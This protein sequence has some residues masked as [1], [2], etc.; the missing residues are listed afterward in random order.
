MTRI[1]L[2]SSTSVRVRPTTPPLTVV[3]VVEP[4]YGRSLAMPPNSEDRCVVGQPVA[5]RV[6]DLRVAHELERHQPDG[7]R[8]VVVGDACC[9]SRS[10]ATSASG[11]PARRRPGPARWSSARRGRTASPVRPA[12][13]LGDRRRDVRRDP[14]GQDDLRRRGRV[15]PRDLEARSPGSRRRRRP[16]H[17]PSPSPPAPE[18]P[19]VRVVPGRTAPSWPSSDT[20]AGPAA[21]AP[22]SRSSGR[23]RCRCCRSRG[24][25]RPARTRRRPRRNV[26]VLRRPARPRSR[27]RGRSRPPRTGGR[28]AWAAPPGS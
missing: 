20:R 15:V 28:A 23:A 5:Q 12:T 11:A 4:G 1:G 3:T 9:A 27:R 21:G 2:S 18:A 25:C 17:P 14:T 8:D 26:Y 19:A 7:P 13:E 10:M 16:R 6:D 22:A 24:R